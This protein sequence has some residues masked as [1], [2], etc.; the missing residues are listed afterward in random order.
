MPG[1][2]SDQPRDTGV[3]QSG[4]A[5]PP[6]P[7]RALVP[8]TLPATPDPGRAFR[9]DARFVTHLIATATLA[10]QTRSL[11]RATAEHVA[12]TYAGACSLP[13]AA[14]GLALSLVA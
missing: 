5:G 7:S 8:L 12:V 6:G 2:F 13:A 1:A 9:P 4:T 14:N 11:R 10:P 3:P